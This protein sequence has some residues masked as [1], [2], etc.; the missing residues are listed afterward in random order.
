MSSQL[1]IWQILDNFCHL[2]GCR[3]NNAAIT[4][5]TYRTTLGNLSKLVSS[6][7][8]NLNPRYNEWVEVLPGI[9]ADG[10]LRNRLFSLRLCPPTKLI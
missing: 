5:Q 9:M 6:K 3:F 4:Y 7:C 8:V 10:L 2:V 1:F